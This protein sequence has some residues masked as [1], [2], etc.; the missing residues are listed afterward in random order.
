MCSRRVVLPLPYLGA[1]RLVF[2][3][4]DNEGKME[5]CTKNP[6]R[7]VTGNFLLLDVGAGLSNALL[8]IAGWRD[9]LPE[10]IIFLILCSFFERLRRIKTKWI[11]LS[12]LSMLYSCHHQGVYT[13]VYYLGLVSF[14]DVVIGL[15][16][17]SSCLQGSTS[18]SYGLPRY[19]VVVP[20]CVLY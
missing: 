10:S 20:H 6:E 12:T 16:P 14:I 4:F 8:G 13:N 7:R 15:H 9:S 17:R 18:R 5:R 3:R 2:R 19:S 11:I 1:I